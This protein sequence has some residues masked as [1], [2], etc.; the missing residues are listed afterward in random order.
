MIEAVS[1]IQSC[2]PATTNAIQQ[3]LLSSS[4]L[5][6]LSQT[7]WPKLGHFYVQ[8]NGKKKVLQVLTEYKMGGWGPEDTEVV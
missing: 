6:F 5:L 3:P 2:Y 1:I 8:I 4:P 7:P